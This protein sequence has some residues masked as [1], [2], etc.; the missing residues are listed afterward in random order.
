MQIAV[1]NPRTDARYLMEKGDKKNAC[2]I[3]NLLRYEKNR[4]HYFWLIAISREIAYILAPSLNS[5][6]PGFDEDCDVVDDYFDH[7]FKF[8]VVSSVGGESVA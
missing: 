2:I 7:E 8:L 4:S 6:L 3:V 5:S 1:T